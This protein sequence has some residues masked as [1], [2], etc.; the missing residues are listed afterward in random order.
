MREPD[1][2]DVAERLFAAITAGDIDAVRD[3]YAS[4]AV[5]WHN[6]DG[7]SQTVEENLRVLTWV[8]RTLT[9]LRYESVRRR[10]TADGFV[11]QHVMRGTTASGQ[12]LELP[13]CIVCTVSG[14]RIARLDE[15]FDS[16]HLAP[17]LSA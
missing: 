10:A 1:A 15:Y 4:D 17:L 12:V 9:A 8:T 6:Y 3:V 5:I 14:D 2:L 7:V 13:A 11:Q 16:A